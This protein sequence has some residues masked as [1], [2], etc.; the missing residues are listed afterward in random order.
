MPRFAPRRSLIAA[1]FLCLLGVAMA[2]D[3]A[4]AIQAI[5]ALT[6]PANIAPLTAP[7]AANDRLHKTLAWLEEA[8]R[9]GMHPSKTLD[10]AQKLTDDNRVHAAAVKETL[11]RNFELCERGAVFTPDNLARM[12]QGRSPAV[13]NGS[14]L[15]E[16]Y[17]VDHIIPVD[18]FPALGNELANLI[19]LPRSLNRRKSDDIQQRAL[20][21]GQK[22]TAAGI[23]TE[24]EYARLRFIRA[25]GD[26]DDSK[27]R[28]ININKAAASTLEKLPGIGP[29]TAAAIIAARPIKDFAALDKVPGIGPKTIEAL[30]E[31]V[32]F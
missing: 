18:E 28:L 23:L 9:A 26:P 6:D 11:L 32:S 13:M 16:P 5:A 29:K 2:A 10:E 25:H 12:R 4:V 21:L 14:R 17:E 8:R 3:P 7:R 15:T 19:Y 31:L 1:A 22:L 30:R 20:D 24:K 27:P